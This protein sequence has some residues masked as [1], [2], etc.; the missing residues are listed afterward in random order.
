MTVDHDAD[1]RR[2]QTLTDI[3][4]FSAT[5]ARLVAR[6]RAAYDADEMLRLAAEAILH[7]IGEAVARLDRRFTEAHPTVRWR[8]MKS[9]RNVVAHE[10]HLVDYGILWNVL[11][12]DLPREAAAVARIVDAER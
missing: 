7:R 8:Q 10:Y 6:G 12:T 9:V 2:Q 4:D 3:L 11:E 1:R 5:A